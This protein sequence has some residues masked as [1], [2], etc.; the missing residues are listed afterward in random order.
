MRRTPFAALALT[1]ALVA[2]TAEAQTLK[3]GYINSQEILASAPGAREAQAAFERD[4]QGFNAEAQQLQDELQRM[5]Q[6]LQQQELTLSPEAKRNRQQQIAQKAQEAQDK[7]AE[8]DQK[9]SGRRA[10]LVQ[11]I[12]DKITEVIEAMREEGNYALILDVAAGSIISADPTLDL[13][14]EVL[15]RLQAATPA[16]G[17]S[18]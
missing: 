5:Q 18:R 10:E 7:M 17:G 9:A 4:M 3:I 8:L 11:P 2:G 12:M 6:Q 15:R 1:F 16:P 14:Q 13:T